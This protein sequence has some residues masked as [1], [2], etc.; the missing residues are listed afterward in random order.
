MRVGHIWTTLLH[1]LRLLPLRLRIWILMKRVKTL[2]QRRILLADPLLQEP[3]PTTMIKMEAPQQSGWPSKPSR[4][5][6]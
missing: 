6:H 1:W 2:Q 3:P 4:F 5:V